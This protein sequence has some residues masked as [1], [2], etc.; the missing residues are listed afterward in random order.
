VG[1]QAGRPVPRRGRGSTGK[2]TLATT[3]ACITSGSAENT[4]GTTNPPERPAPRDNETPEP[5]GSRVSYV[6]RD[7]NGAGGGVPFQEI[8]DT[9]SQDIVDTS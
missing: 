4:P 8:V 9:M 3:G 6:V 7:H 5:E 2:I 1:G